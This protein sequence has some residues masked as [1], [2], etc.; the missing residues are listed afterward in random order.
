MMYPLAE[1]DGKMRTTEWTTIPTLPA[2]PDGEEETEWV[3]P[4]KF[5]DIQFPCHHWP[6]AR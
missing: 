3:V 2:P 1:Y 5:A 4:D 6:A